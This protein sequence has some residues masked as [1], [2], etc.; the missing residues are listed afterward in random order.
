MITEVL[1]YLGAATVLWFGIVLHPGTFSDS[2]H[3]DFRGVSPAGR[4][5]IV[6]TSLILLGSA[7]LWATHI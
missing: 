5:C 4:L 7:L 3:A 1:Q 2:Q 6:L